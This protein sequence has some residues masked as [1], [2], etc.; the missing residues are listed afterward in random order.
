MTELTEIT[1]LLLWPAQEHEKNKRIW[2]KH[3]RTVFLQPETQN[4]A[5]H[6]FSGLS[7]YE[8]KT[9]VGP[10]TPFTWW[11]K[12]EAFFINLQ[13]KERS[14]RMR[15]NHWHYHDLV[16]LNSIRSNRVTMIISVQNPWRHQEVSLQV[17]SRHHLKG[18]LFVPRFL[19]CPLR[20]EG[21][22][23]AQL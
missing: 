15:Q 22:C 8:D 4:W 5:A 11:Y 17:G 13:F 12:Y 19:S 10:F 23:T 21:G 3:E 7:L 9:W 2:R 14:L 1:L 20:G 18:R 6:N 16:S